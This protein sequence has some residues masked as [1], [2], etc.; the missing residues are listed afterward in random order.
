LVEDVAV[1]KRCPPTAPTAAASSTTRAK[2]S[3]F[4]DPAL[5]VMRRVD[6]PELQAG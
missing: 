5:E 6:T 3:L 1:H 4:R 2:I